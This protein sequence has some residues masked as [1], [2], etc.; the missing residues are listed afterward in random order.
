VN[1][2]REGPEDQNS[3]HAD[4][5]SAEYLVVEEGGQADARF[6][7]NKNSHV[8]AFSLVGGESLPDEKSSD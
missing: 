8:L 1:C 6:R 7:E 5:G 3:P 2:T 4:Y